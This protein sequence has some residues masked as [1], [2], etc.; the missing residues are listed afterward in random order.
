MRGLAGAQPFTVMSAD[1]TVSPAERH[2]RD[3]VAVGGGGLVEDVLQ[4]EQHGRARHVA[5]VAQRGA[6]GHELGLAELQARLDL[7]EDAA[8]ARMDGP[9]RDA[10]ARG[11]RRQRVGEVGVGCEQR[12]ERAGDVVVDD[13]GDRVGEHHLEAVVAD[14]PRH[15]ALADRRDARLEPVERERPLRPS[16][17]AVTIPAPAP[18]AKS[19]DATIVSGSFDERRC[20]VQSSTLTTST[21]ASGSASQ[22]C[23]ALRSAGIDA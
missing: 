18:S 23:T 15:V 3:A 10:L 9:V 7:V 13:R 4:H 14:L 20:S 5:E 22:N 16:G 8:P 2:G 1:S 19:D 17:R 6:R 12:L 21:T 11:I